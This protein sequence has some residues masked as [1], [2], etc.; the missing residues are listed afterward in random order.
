MIFCPEVL[1]L[2]SAHIYE[3]NTLLWSLKHHH[4]SLLCSALVS[5]NNETFVAEKEQAKTV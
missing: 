3:R 1:P 2:K 4:R 5:L